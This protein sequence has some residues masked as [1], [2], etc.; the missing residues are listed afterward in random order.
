MN[1][2]QMG[3]RC[4]KVASVRIVVAAIRY[5]VNARDLQLECGSVA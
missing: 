1:Q 5:L 3:Q 4:R 2:V